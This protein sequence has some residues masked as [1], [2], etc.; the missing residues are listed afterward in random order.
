MHIVERIA[1]VLF[2]VCL[3]EDAEYLYKT[4]SE[5]ASTTKNAMNLVT[6]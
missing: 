6:V 2:G 4:G 5:L 1:K 3:D